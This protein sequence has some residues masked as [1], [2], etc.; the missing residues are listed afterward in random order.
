MQK[1]KCPTMPSHN[2]NQSNQSAPNEA[3]PPGGVIVST[4][5]SNLSL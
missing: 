2:T 1:L 5:E 3:H 4:G